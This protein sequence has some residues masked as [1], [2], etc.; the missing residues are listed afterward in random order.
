MAVGAF[1]QGLVS[2]YTTGRQMKERREKHDL[3]M[4][5]ARDDKEM[6][7][8]FKAI[9]ATHEI[10]EQY[11]VATDEGDV[12]FA[13]RAEAMAAAGDTGGIRPIYSVAGQ[14]YNTTHEAQ[15]AQ[16]IMNDP[17]TRMGMMAQVAVAYGRPELATQFYGAQQNMLDSQRRMMQHQ[18]L[19]AQRTG[20]LEGVINQM[21]HLVGPG[22][23]QT[24][25]VQGE[26]G[27]VALQR[28]NPEDGSVLSEQRFENVGSLWNGLYEDVM[29]TPD[30]MLAIY[31]SKRNQDFQERQFAHRQSVDAQQLSLSAANTG[32]AAGNLGLRRQEFAAA[33]NQPRN[34]AYHQGTD[35]E[36]NLAVARSWMSV[37]DKGN[38]VTNMSDPMSTG[39][40]PL[41]NRS[42]GFDPFGMGGP[43]QPFALP[44]PGQS[45]LNYGA[46]VN[47]DSQPTPNQPAPARPSGSGMPTPEQ[48]AQPATREDAAQAVRDSLPGSGIRQDP[49]P[50]G[51][52][53]SGLVTPMTP[54]QAEAYRQGSPLWAGEDPLRNTH[55]R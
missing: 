12:I 14:T 10:G 4:E 35:A 1:A 24:Q 2:G 33:Q 17:G 50:V 25:V 9:E 42:G 27:Q 29:A 40:S 6:R 26:G 45:N 46:P 55:R 37:D 8:A 36:G 7:D 41:G 18:F 39:V 44:D 53:S 3:E 32:I 49:A 19:H 11:V 51:P 13:D 23:P 47:P 22:N 5:R 43:P 30:N 15:Q 28:V 16:D 20:D 54:E 38:P 31:T 48:P 21:N 52:T 34:V